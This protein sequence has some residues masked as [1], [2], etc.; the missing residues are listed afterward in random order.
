MFSL[1]TLSHH[2]NIDLVRSRLYN[3]QS[4]YSAFISDINRAQ[5]LVVIESP[6]ITHKRLLSLYPT[7]KKATQR[8]VRIVINTR[9]PQTH[10][11]FMMNQALDAIVWLQEL[12]ITVLYTGNLHRK[13]AIVDDHILWEGSL[14]ILS[15]SDSCEMMRRSESANLVSEMIRFTRLAKWY[16]KVRI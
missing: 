7:L 2:S 14:N 13:V 9:D 10:D 11:V 15:Q 16:T 6:F 8:G 1:K 4:F 12:D 5:S 3:E